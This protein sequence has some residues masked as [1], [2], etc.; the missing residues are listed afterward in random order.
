MASCSP[1]APLD[2]SF[3]LVR[4]DPERRHCIV[5]GGNRIAQFLE[6]PDVGIELGDVTLD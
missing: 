3:E 2:R 1:R 4:A 5:S 6:L